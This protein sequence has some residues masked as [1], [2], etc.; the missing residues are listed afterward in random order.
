MLIMDMA[1]IEIQ[2]RSHGDLDLQNLDSA[3]SAKE[4]DAPVVKLI[5]QILVSAINHRASD[6]HFEPYEKTYRIRYRQDGLLTEV[7]AP[8]IHLANQ[9]NVRIKVLANLDISERRLPQ[10]GHFQLKLAPN[11]VVDCR[12]STCPTIYGEKLVVRILDTDLTRLDVDSLGLN[13]VQKT[14]FL[15]ALAKPQGLIVITGPT[16]SGKTLSL[17]TA[18]TILN[19]TERNISTAEDPVEIRIPGIN[20]VGINPKSGLTFPT[21]LRSFLRQDPDI[22]M[23]GEIRDLETAEIAIKA[24]QTGHLVLSTLHANSAA[25]TLDRLIN[26]GIPAFN[27]ANSAILLVAQRL[28]RRICAHCKAQ[29]C[30][31]CSNGFRGRLGLFEIIPLVKKMKQAIMAG[32]NSLEIQ[33]LAQTEGLLTIYQSGLEKVAQGLTTLAEVNRVTT[34]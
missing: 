7:A 33:N 15:A 20:Q 18:L 6:I 28:V 16:G 24:A 3:F 8:P 19:S 5:N 26:I 23:I 29:G 25:E 32:A 34:E 10:D 17:Y 1:T 12:V 11:H 4:S 31:H 13:A 22:I 21:I 2:H 14:H 9:I 27:I 30:E